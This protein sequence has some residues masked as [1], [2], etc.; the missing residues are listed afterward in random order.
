[1]GGR[2]LHSGG[3]RGVMANFVWGVV[4]YVPSDV[5]VIAFTG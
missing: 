3:N 2:Y 1:V 5:I 4:A